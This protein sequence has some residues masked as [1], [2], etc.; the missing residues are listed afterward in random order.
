MTPRSA[1][2]ESMKRL[3]ANTL[4]I[5]DSITAR[6][7][8]ANYIEGAVNSGVPGQ[9]SVDICGRF[10]RDAILLAPKQICLLAGTNDVIRLQSSRTNLIEQMAAW[11]LDQRIPIILAKMP[12][13]I[14]DIPWLPTALLME[15]IHEWN[16]GV[17]SV[18]TALTLPVADYFTPLCIE[19]EDAANPDLFID[20]VHPNT[21]GYD[22]MFAALQAVGG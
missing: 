17:D 14:S 21:A 9:T 10:N 6:W 5:G 19:G 1:C 20:G 4:F 13:L 3:S 16:D 2:G 8:V 11:A 18:G 15:I 12:P 22:V 7:P